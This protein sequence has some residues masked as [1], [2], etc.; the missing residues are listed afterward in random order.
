M[1]AVNDAALHLDSDIVVSMD[2]LWTE[3]RWAML[4]ARARPAWLRQSAVQR[5]ADRPPWLRVF[6]CDVSSDEFAETEGMLNGGNSGFCAFNLAY[7]KRPRRIFLFGFDM[8]RG[9][10]GEPYWYKGYS[11]AKPGGATSGGKFEAWRRQFEIAA[12]KCAAVNIAVVNVSQRSAIDFFP[13]VHPRE[14]AGMTS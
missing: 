6:A 14:L 3:H 1:I 10:N 2:R 4:A 11:W 5:I 7:Q 12:K 8:K 9:P 13:K